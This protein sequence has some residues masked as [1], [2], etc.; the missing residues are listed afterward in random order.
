MQ[1]LGH[2]HIRETYARLFRCIKTEVQQ[3]LNRPLAPTTIQSDFELAAIRAAEQE[4][5][6]ADTKGCFFHYAQALWGKTQQLGLTVAYKEDP[7]VRKWVRRAC[8]LALL[9]TNTVQDTWIEIM[10]GTTNV[11]TFRRL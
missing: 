1:G 9:P 2:C 11:S 6:G 5:P 4:F 8:G 3:R 10:D 7:A